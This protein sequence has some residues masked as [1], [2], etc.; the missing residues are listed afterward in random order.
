M[1]AKVIILLVILIAAI[2]FFT[3]GKYDFNIDSD[4]NIINLIK[5]HFKIG[6]KDIKLGHMRR[7]I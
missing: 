3:C 2:D 7:N 6:Q 4:T 1:Y 5:K